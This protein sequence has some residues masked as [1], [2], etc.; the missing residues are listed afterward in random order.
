MFVSIRHLNGTVLESF[1]RPAVLITDAYNALLSNQ[2]PRRQR[3]QQFLD[4]ILKTLR[5]D[6]K[7]LLPV[8]TAGRVLE[9]I[10]ILEQVE[11]AGGALR[12]GEYVTLRK[13]G[14]SSQKGGGNIQQIILEGPLT[15]EYYKIRDHLYSQFYAL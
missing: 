1:V 11:F 2:P 9:L 7:I 3:D 15:E 14:D 8:D 4:A 10:L 12:C 13:I 5:A 6:G